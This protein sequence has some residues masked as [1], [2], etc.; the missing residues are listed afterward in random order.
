MR[1]RVCARTWPVENRAAFLPVTGPCCRTCD[2]F[3]LSWLACLVVP[4]SPAVSWWPTLKPFLRGQKE[5][6]AV[7]VLWTGVGQDHFSCLGGSRNPQESQ[8]P[9]PTGRGGGK[10]KLCHMQSFP[11]WLRPHLDPVPSSVSQAVTG[12]VTCSSVLS[13]L[14]LR[15]Q[16]DVLQFENLP[17]TQLNKERD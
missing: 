2:H 5:D 8:L 7:T 6:S 10:P 12:G 3:N 17:A 4:A 11:V 1:V 14:C 9:I 13:E 15:H 16:L